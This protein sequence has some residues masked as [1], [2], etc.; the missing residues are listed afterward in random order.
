MKKQIKWVFVLLTIMSLSFSMTSCKKVPA[1]N[2]RIKFYLLGTSKGVDY[3]ELKPGR[4]WIGINEELFLFPTFTQN[5]I[6][7][8]DSQEGSETDESFTFQDKNG[9]ELKADVGI[10]YHLQPD[11]IDL[12]FQK[13]K[14]GINE[15]TDIFLRNM[16]R[17][18]LVNRTS[19]LD[20][21]YIYGQGR[22]KLLD[23]VTLDVRKQCEPIGILVDKIYWI[24]KITLPPTVE[25]A[26]N[27]KI[28]ATQ[29]AQQRENELRETEAAAK[30]QIAQADGAA[31]SLR[32]K[33]DAEAY[34]NRTVSGSL[35]PQI[36]EMKRL[37]KW[38]G[39]YPVTYG[40]NGGLMIK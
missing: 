8:A 12:I 36:V 4:Y 17:D 20:I 16:V 14:K 23:S 22:A 40:L 30:K 35:T 25:E 9:S 7:T 28:K 32:I 27:S 39:K 3:E 34:Y 33:A 5:Y 2:V 37:E 38:D 10:T 31:K 29:I 1:G 6:W 21:E 11:K 13:Y 18:A 15:I 24:G 19:M 26:I